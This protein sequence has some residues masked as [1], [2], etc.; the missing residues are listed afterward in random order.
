[1]PDLHA[2][3][4][5]GPAG[6]LA[7]AGT[8]IG[9][10]ARHFADLAAARPPLAFLEVHAENYMGAGGPP[11]RWLD[12]LRESYPLSIHGVGLSLGSAG[13]LHAGHL[14][15]LARVVKRFQPALVSEHLAWCRSGETWLNDLLPIPYDE[16][17]LALLVDHVDETQDRLRRRLLIENPSAYVGWCGSTIA[18]AQFLA[19]LAAETGCGILLDVNNLFVSAC[20]LGFDPLAYLDALPPA[21]IGQYHLA[22]H[23]H[24]RLPEGGEIRIDDHG[25]PVADPVWQ[26]FDAALRRFGPRPTLVE[27]D[28]DVPPLDVLLAEAA[29]A[30]RHLAEGAR[31]VRAG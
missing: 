8:G 9:A 22:G 11:H 19:A 25:S 24:R 15:A 7:M 10:K 13:P 23:H 27:W 31:H 5:T 30:G 29:R 21:A 14:D 3:P 16:A 4:R 18:E 26:L 6:G 1:M 28:S 17:T 2:G 12:V 20:N